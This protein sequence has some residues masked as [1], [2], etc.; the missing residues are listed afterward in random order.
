MLSGKGATPGRSAAKVCGASHWSIGRSNTRRLP[1]IPAW[2]TFD[3]MVAYPFRVHGYRVTA[4]INA[5]NIFDRR[6]FSDIQS[7]GF[8]PDG[9]FSSETAI[10]GDPRDVVG[11]L[12]VDF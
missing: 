3:L 5:T 6:Y 1:L 7:P 10:W 9:P 11:T 8:P 2:Q 12:R 4:Q